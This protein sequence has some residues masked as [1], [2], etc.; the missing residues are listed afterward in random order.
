VFRGKLALVIDRARLAIVAGRKSVMRPGPAQDTFILALSVVVGV[1]GAISA[2]VFYWLIRMANAGLVNAPVQFWPAAASWPYRIV[3]MG[4]CLALAAWIVRRVGDGYDGLN[5]PDVSVA[6][7][8]HGGRLPG[9]P[10]VAKTLASAVTVGGGGSAGS[11]GPIAVLSAAV[12]SQMASRLGLAPRQVRTLVGAGAGAGIAAAFNVPLAGAFFALEEILRSFSSV[13][14]AP[15]V[16]S[17]VVGAVVG[18]ALMGSH[19]AFS[20][21]LIVGYQFDSELF[22]FYPLLGI[23]AGI[24]SA[25]FIRLEGTVAR[26][27][28]RALIPGRLIPFVGGAI[29]ALAVLL[30]GGVLAGRGHIEVDLPQLASMSW[31]VALLLAVSKAVVTAVTLN[32]GGSGGVFAPALAIGAFT[33][34][35]VAGIIRVVFPDLPVDPTAYIVVGMG[36]VIAAATGATLTGLFFVFELSRNYALMMPLMMAVVLATVVRRSLTK[37]NLYSAWL[38]RTGRQSPSDPV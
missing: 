21:P 25:V 22:F 19:P 23:L 5:V 14:F 32:S 15:V 1:I 10:A 33:G 28:W 31:Q 38:E 8:Q 17:S 12:A 13:A 27:R 9:R 16:V 35:A 4:G 11:E 7:D 34:A 3:L 30:S 18:Q 26:H 29:V 2:A 24:I 6:V 37:H 36:C 20:A